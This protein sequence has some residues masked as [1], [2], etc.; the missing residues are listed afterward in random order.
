MDLE[1]VCVCMHVCVG[2]YHLFSESPQNVLLPACRFITGIMHSLLLT[3]PFE[4]MHVITV[5]SK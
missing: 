3:L 2:L 4:C 1:A 5:F